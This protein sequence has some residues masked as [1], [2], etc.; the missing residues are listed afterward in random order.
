MFQQFQQLKLLATETDFYTVIQQ[1]KLLATETD[2]YTVTT[3]K[4]VGFESLADY[5][6]FKAVGFEFFV[7]Q[8]SIFEGKSC[9]K[10][11]LFEIFAFFLKIYSCLRLIFEIFFGFTQ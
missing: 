8:F 11:M 9:T 7:F 5:V 4:A 2:F 6:L 10:L 3:A 1:L